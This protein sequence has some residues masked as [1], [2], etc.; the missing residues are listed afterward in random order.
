MSKQTVTLDT[1]NEML[2]VW[3]VESLLCRNAATAYSMLNMWKKNYKPVCD[4]EHF[5]EKMLEEGSCII[6][7]VHVET[8][9]RLKKGVYCQLETVF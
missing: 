5:A 9:K 1:R 7:L 3:K 8:E 4:F 6:D 2:K